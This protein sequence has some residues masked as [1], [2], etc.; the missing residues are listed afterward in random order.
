MLFF[1]SGIPEP[2]LPKNEA[3]SIA[4]EIL[5]KNPNHRTAL[6]VLKK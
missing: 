2:L 6:D 1:Y 3:I 5:K 4:K